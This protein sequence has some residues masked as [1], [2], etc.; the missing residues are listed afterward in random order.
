MSIATAK[1]HTETATNCYHCGDPCE[2]DKIV[3]DDKD[4]CCQGCKTV[5]E[6]LSENELCNYYD[7]EASPG[8]TLKDADEKSVY[9][10]LDNEAIKARMLDFSGDNYEKVSFSVP[11]IHCSS[12]IW[13]LENLDRLNEAVI[14]SKVDFSNKTVTVHYHSQDMNLREVAEM[15]DSIGYAPLINLDEDGDRKKKEATYDRQLIIKMGVAGFCFGNIM[16]LSFPDYLGLTGIE[17]NYQSFFRYLNVLLAL[18]VVFYA[19]ADYFVSAFRSIRQRYANI[20]IPIALGVSV[21]FL[22]SFYEVATGIGPGYFD[23]LVGL[24]FYLLIGKWFQNKTYRSMSFDRDYKSYFPLAVLKKEESSLTSTQ[25]TELVKGDEIAMRNGEIIPADAILIDDEAAIDYSFITGESEAVQQKKGDY[26]YAGGRHTGPMTRMIVQKEVSQSYLT[27]LWNDDAFSKAEEGRSMIDRISK[28]FTLTIIGIA[29]LAGLYWQ[30][31]NPANTWLVFTAVLIVACPCALALVTP[32]TSGSV[33]RVLGRNKFYLKNASVVEKFSAI[34][35]VVFDKTG[36]I[37]HTT[38]KAVSFSGDALSDQEKALVLP[39]VTGSTHPLSR[40]IKEF[41]GKPEK[42]YLPESFTELPG[43]GIDAT[44]AGVKVLL[45]SARFVGAEGGQEAGLTR[46]YLTIGSRIRGSF[47]IRSQYR[48]GIE[49]CVQELAKD[50]KLAVLSGDNNNEAAALR[51]FFPES[52]AMKFNQSPESKLREI[53]TIQEQGH[54]VVMLGDGLNDAGALKQSDIGIAVTEDI[55]AF[56]PASD[57]ILEASALS[58]LNQLLRF[59]K[60]SRK[61]I[62]ASFVLSFLYNVV[63]V[64]LAVMGVFTPLI[65]AILMPLSSI[66]VVFFTTFGVHLFAKRFKLS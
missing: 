33:M 50:H 22:R 6:I 42:E 2:S 48:D 26:L 52:T 58:K 23:S 8:Q 30:F 66:S 43:K 16:L 37:T 41:L 14:D 62:W 4:F 53:K 25:V 13:L 61:V 54:G 44:V 9:D 19:G 21:L 64:S 39:V 34:D 5:Y 63:G 40:L 36:T 1:Q 32:F 12:C 35:S 49:S 20:D 56:S 55:A 46:V 31:T 45:G 28:Y 60:S 18:P 7:L 3:S 15:L 38:N 10:F 59:G 17:Q 51:Q 57:A 65:A 27:R 29:V 47:A 24:I 11:A